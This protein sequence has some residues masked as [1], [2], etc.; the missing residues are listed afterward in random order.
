MQL[1][2]VVAHE[3]TRLLVVT[4]YPFFFTQPELPP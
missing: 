4:V 1:A 3:P 2:A